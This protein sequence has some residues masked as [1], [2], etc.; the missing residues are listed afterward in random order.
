MPMTLLFLPIRFGMAAM[1]SLKNG[2]EAV[3]NR[4]DIINTF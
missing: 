1:E 4:V 2:V 3:P